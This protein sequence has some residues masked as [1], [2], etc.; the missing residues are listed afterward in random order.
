MAS[1]VNCLHLEEKTLVFDRNS[2]TAWL[3]GLLD[4][5]FSALPNPSSVTIEKLSAQDN[6][7]PIENAG[8]NKAKTTDL[9]ESNGGGTAP[10]RPSP[11][12]V[13]PSPQSPSTG[14]DATRRGPGG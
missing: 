4:P 1:L 7:G 6:K 12:T 13:R 2:L 3:R 9:T 8:V 14:G 10:P 5:S 11:E